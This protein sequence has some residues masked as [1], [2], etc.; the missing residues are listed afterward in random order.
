[1]KI[2][3]EISDNQ[4]IKKKKERDGIVGSINLPRLFYVYAERG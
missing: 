4:Q 1:M 3:E 2:K